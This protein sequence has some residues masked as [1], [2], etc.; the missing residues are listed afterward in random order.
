MNAGRLSIARAVA[1]VSLAA[2]VA[3][4]QA[5]TD[6]SD[7]GGLPGAGLER[8]ANALFQTDSLSYTL[9]PGQS[10]YRARIGVQFTNATGHD[11]YF[12]NCNNATGL[13]LEKLEGGEWR[14]AWYPVL[15]LCLSVPIVVE[16][17]STYDMD[18]DV[19]GG[20]PDNDHYPKFLV[21]DV[22]G[23]YRIVWDAAYS[24]YEK[25]GASNEALPPGQRVSNRFT[26]A[27]EG[28]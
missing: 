9:H 19:F 2:A 15:P 1:L 22:D 25:D 14:T 17:G 6:A 16:P 11:V 18:V 24:Y 26:M 28:R 27:V 3:C 21:D 5:P 7:P 10:G 20:Y 4:G 8:E 12:A 23:V 13:T